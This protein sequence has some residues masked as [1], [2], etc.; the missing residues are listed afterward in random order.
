VHTEANEAT[1]H[2][3]SADAPKLKTVPPAVPK[4]EWK[5]QACGHC[6]RP[7]LAWLQHDH[8]LFGESGLPPGFDKERLWGD[9]LPF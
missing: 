5:E 1:D 8:D 3:D 7:Q 2:N 6:G 9:N 4:I